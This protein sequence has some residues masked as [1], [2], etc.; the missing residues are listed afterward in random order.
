M[1]PRGDALMFRLAPAPQPWPAIAGYLDAQGL[2]LDLAEPPRQFAGGLANLNYLVR[3][4]GAPA[5]LR[6]PPDGD[7]APGASDMAREARVLAALN[8]QLPL[9]PRLLHACLDASVIG[10]PFLLIEY[11]SGVAVGGTLP[12]GIRAADGKWMTM[13]LVQAMAALHALE[14]I[15]DL[16]MLGKPTGFNARQL[17]GWTKRAAA[18][19][20]TEAPPSLAG[21]LGG[22]E[23][24]LPPDAPARPLHMDPK[25]DN[26]LVDPAAQR[27]TAM[28]DWDMGTLGPPAFDLA[29]LLSYWVTPSDP[30]PLHALQAVPALEPGW[31][32]PADA[33]AA[34]GRAAGHM[35][36]DLPWHLALARLRLA[37]AWM[38]LYRLWQHG[39]LAGDRYS[40]FQTI[41][42]AMLD[43]AVQQFGKQP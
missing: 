31:P 32:T 26:L 42:N 27:A 13:A 7:L 18:A 5:V 43:H 33:V 17:A 41:A 28:L 10:V 19:F 39:N 25:F 24:A 38:Q 40:G 4:D 12:E 23:S 22:L 2:R 14:P 11:R 16:A 34:Y 1:Q 8:P 37:T 20:G 3:L 29:V 9:A 35:P 36:P 6:R 21:L 15:G 30:E